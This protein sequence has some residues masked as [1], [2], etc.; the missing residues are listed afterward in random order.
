MA[1]FAKTQL[2]KYG[3]TEGK[4]LG[5]NEN[6]ITQ[7]LKPKLKFD[8]AGIG[9]K[10]T[11]SNQWWETVFNTAANNINIESK[12]NEVA[13]SILEK[14]AVD[15]P[16]KKNY[17]S[18][19]AKHRDY[20]NFLKTSTL[21]DG[22]LLPEND[23]D[24]V[25]DVKANVIYTPLT[26]EELFK[27]CGGRTAH[28]GAR[29]G[30]KLNGKLSRIARQEAK[31]LGTLMGGTVSSAIDQQI[32]LKVS[33]VEVKDDE[34]VE[35]K[36]DDNANTLS[37]VECR[38]VPK[39]KRT[40]KEHKGRMNNLTHQL[41]LSC[42]ITDNDKDSEPNSSADTLDKK[43]LKRKRS[44]VKLQSNMN[45]SNEL[46]T[47]VCRT[48]LS[49]NENETVEKS[50]M[51]RGQKGD[52]DCA[53][54]GSNNLRDDM[55]NAFFLHS[56]KVKNSKRKC[57]KTHQ[58][59]DL[60]Q[61]EINQDVTDCSEPKRLKKSAIKKKVDLT[62]DVPEKNT[63]IGK[64]KK[65]KKVSFQEPIDFNTLNLNDGSS[66]IEECNTAKEAHRLNLRLIK[67]KQAKFRRKLK[68]KMKKL[69]KQQETESINDINTKKK[70]D[71]I[72]ETLMAVDLKESIAVNKKKN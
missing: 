64:E 49:V 65:L 52:T 27:A 67:K 30:L 4:G 20:G 46:E 5:K 28:K 57:S 15:I 32:K 29:H 11:D 51:I 54:N 66:S 37:Y 34:F 55:E 58:V 9:H 45:I 47:E 16:L 24:S 70:L 18:H 60:T 33:K 12:S 2:M 13:I 38:P 43:K 53:E 62:V 17:K 3:W 31:L 41:S 6:G 35:D 59:K 48:S 63:K 68:N 1:N 25:E 42:N 7:A 61:P 72:M 71:S 26:D 23:S 50:K 10:D 14:D 8:T 21:C 40:K 69:A 22:N 39:S 19:K 36:C 56:V 44:E